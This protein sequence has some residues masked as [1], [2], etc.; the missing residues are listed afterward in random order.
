MTPSTPRIP[1]LF[2]QIQSLQGSM[3]FEPVSKQTQCKERVLQMIRQHG[4]ISADSIARQTGIPDHGVYRVL[5]RLQ[6]DG[7]ITCIAINRTKHWRIEYA[8]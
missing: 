6:A 1:T 3:T 8:D 5:S 7:T 2:D 4:P